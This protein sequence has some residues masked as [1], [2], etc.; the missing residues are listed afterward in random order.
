MTHC[1]IERL[2]RHL[3]LLPVLAAASLLKAQTLVF[4]PLP[5]ENQE[6]VNAAWRPFLG[7]LETR[8]GVEFRIAYTD[9]Y[10]ALLDRFASGQI[11]L[12]YLGPLPYVELKKRLPQAA[13]LVHFKEKSGEAVYTCALFAP[14][15]A[16]L[17][18]KGLTGKKIAL[19]QPLSTCGYL[20]ASGLLRKAGAD[21]EKNR[22]RYLDRH[23]AVLEAVAAGEFD[24]GS[25]KTAIGKKYA[26]LGLVALAETPPFPGF[27]LIAHGGRISTA[28]Q[29]L[30][31][32]L[33]IEA[34]LDERARWGEMIRHG[35]G[36]VE[37]R[38]YA[39]V[40]ALLPDHP[41]PE[42]GNF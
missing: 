28:R 13:P 41:I 25:V 12:A 17:A 23:D 2:V 31:Q 34:P 35:A 15:E 19:T 24:L 18:L 9:S 1:W 20:A 10:A 27:A 22:Y 26:S 5:M 42:K 38:H 16:K 40:R 29:K 30:I 6:A 14:A 4:A 11:D 33:V 32:Q 3:L 21:I 37:D 39:G 36:A 7:Y 8:L